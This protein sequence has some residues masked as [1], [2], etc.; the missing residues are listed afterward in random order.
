MILYWSSLHEIFEKKNVTEGSKT[1]TFLSNFNFF[2]RTGRFFWKTCF[3]ILS[4]LR[5]VSPWSCVRFQPV[6]GL[7]PQMVVGFPKTRWFTQGCMK[8]VRK[9]SRRSAVQAQNDNPYNENSVFGTRCRIRRICRKR[10]RQR[11]VR[12][13]SHTRRGPRW[14]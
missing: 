13:S 8:K 9:T 4:R 12:P 6:V 1:L 10:C 11:Q 7:S 14:R 2:E 5:W 3:F